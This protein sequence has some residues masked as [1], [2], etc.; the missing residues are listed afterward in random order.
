MSEHPSHKLNAYKDD[1]FTWVTYCEVCGL[2]QE[3]L[4]EPCTGKFVERKRIA[5]VDKT[6]KV[7]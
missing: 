6:D 4:S 3:N 2:E 7:D 5:V 1:S